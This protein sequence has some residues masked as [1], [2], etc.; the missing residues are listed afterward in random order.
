MAH[1]LLSVD[2][3]AAYYNGAVVALTG[4]TFEVAQGEILALLGSNGAGKSTILK[5]VSRLLK[6]ERGA[7]TAGRS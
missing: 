3:I 4:V 2:G 7:L 6:A 1:P 5:A